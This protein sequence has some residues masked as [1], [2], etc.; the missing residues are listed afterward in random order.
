MVE[1]IYRCCICKKII[2][3]NHRL[4]RMDWGL[5][6]FKD[7]GTVAHYDFCDKHYQVFDKWI[8]KHK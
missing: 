5:G 7:F 2:K 6:R 4:I 3:R 1:K 8:K